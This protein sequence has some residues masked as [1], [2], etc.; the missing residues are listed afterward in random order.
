MN[1]KFKGKHSH[2]SVSVCQKQMRGS[3]RRGEE[4]REEKWGGRRGQ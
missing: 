4:G 2:C 1:V 3:E